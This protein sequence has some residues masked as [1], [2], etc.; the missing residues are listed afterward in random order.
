[1]RL[2]NQK[3][4]PGCREKR[5]YAQGIYSKNCENRRSGAV[6]LYQSLKTRPP[7]PRIFGRGFKINAR[8]SIFGP[9]QSKP[10]GVESQRC[11]TAH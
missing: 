6:F 2:F 5:D 8:L 7:A 10:I 4:A 9:H 11:P 1:M 3:I